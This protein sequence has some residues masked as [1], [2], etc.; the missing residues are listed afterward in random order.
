MTTYLQ[1]RVFGQ[2][3][4]QTVRPELATEIARQHVRGF[5][6]SLAWIRIVE[7]ASDERQ[8]KT[9]AECER[10]MDRIV[11]AGGRSGN[12]GWP[13]CADGSYMIR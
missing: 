1:Y 6:Q 7:A 5:G 4:T 8:P 13:C 2:T 12:I 10:V 11:A 9:R 3:V